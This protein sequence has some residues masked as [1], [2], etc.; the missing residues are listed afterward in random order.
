MKQNETC[1]PSAT[2]AYEDG[3]APE[4]SGVKLR[5]TIDGEEVEVP[6]EETSNEWLE[7]VSSEEY[8]KL[9]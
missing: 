6:G 2:G 7:A 9:D 3:S 5:F 1:D 8:E 4:F